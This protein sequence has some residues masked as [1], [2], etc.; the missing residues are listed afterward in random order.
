MS[1]WLHSQANITARPSRRPC[2]ARA[3]CDKNKRVFRLMQ[4]KRENDNN[5]V[6]FCITT[7]H[8]FQT[9]FVLVT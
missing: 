1:G 7:H 6:L 3:R 2:S 8:S 5:S 9:K 4:I